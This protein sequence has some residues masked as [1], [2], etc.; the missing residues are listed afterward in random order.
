MK[1]FIAAC[2]YFAIC[3]VIIG[4]TQSAPQKTAT[5]TPTTVIEAT[6]TL[7]S[8][9]P[10]ASFL[11]SPDI[12][13]LPTFVLNTPVVGT[14]APY[15]TPD[16]NNFQKPYFEQTEIPGLLQSHLTLENLP[17]FNGNIIQ[18]ISGWRYG[19]N[20]LEW[21]DA[22][23]LLL[24]PNAGIYNIGGGQQVGIFPAVASLDSDT[25]WI[26]LPNR[27]GG[28]YYPSL[29]RWSAKLGILITATSDGS[30]ALYNP[31]GKV[32]KIYEGKFLGISPSATKLLIDDTWI[33]LSSSKMVK[34]AWQ[35]DEMAA[36]FTDSFHPIWSPDET[37]VYTC[38]YLY[39]DAKTGESQVMPYYQI[40]LDGE[41][42]QFILEELYGT[43]VLNDKYVL[44]IWGGIWDGRYGAVYLFDPA[45]KT[46]RNLS[47]LA[48]ITYQWQGDADP[49]C[50]QPSA[51][52][53]GRYVWVDCLDGGHLIDLVTFRSQAYPPPA[54][55]PY[56]G[57]Y[58]NTQDTKWSADGNFVW[59]NEEGAESILSGATGEL[60]PLP[61]NCY[62]FEWHPKDN[63]LLCMSDDDQKLLLL[64]AQTISVKKEFSLPA[65]FGEFTWSPDGKYIELVASDK[66]VW[67]LSYPH[68][69]DFEQL[70]SSV[71][72]TGGAK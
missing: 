57:G 59:F 36:N 20:S 49:Y 15:S 37:R 9:L 30:V 54:D 47:A 10:T 8:V 63:V 55:G 70:D 7:N 58:Y 68:L 61:R 21:M 23:H 67:Q 45:A 17:S 3:L 29:P 19:F 50:T 62:G 4:C 51:Q 40:T 26:P 64:D 11:P 44:P 2:S 28:E 22:N 27:R 46:Y 42:T 43:W 72:T 60:K 56:G 16:L 71:I 31:D 41:K 13:A 69:E 25:F 32:R 24:Y 6:T 48:G 65:K 33:D 35:Q 38:C 52:N 12:D 66:S 18:R 1:N 53:G 5:T 39:G 34:F 14:P